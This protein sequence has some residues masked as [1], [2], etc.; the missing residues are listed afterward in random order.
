MTDALAVF[1]GEAGTQIR[2]PGDGCSGC[3]P[4]TTPVRCCVWIRTDGV[5]DWTGGLGKPR[6]VC[7]RQAGACG[8]PSS[9]RDLAHLLLCKL[10]VEPRTR[11]GVRQSIDHSVASVENALH[12]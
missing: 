4:A 3:F 7:G 12:G 8:F 5:S 11:A 2:N 1:H 10:D 6:Q 9:Q